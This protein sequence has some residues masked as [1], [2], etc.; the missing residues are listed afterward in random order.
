[1]PVT[2]ALR[3]PSPV[4]FTSGGVW[5]SRRRGRRHRASALLA[6]PHSTSHSPDSHSAR[7]PRQF[8]AQFHYGGQL[9]RDSLWSFDSG[10]AFHR[11]SRRIVLAM[12]ALAVRLLAHF[13]F[14]LGGTTPLPRWLLGRA[15]EVLTF[16]RFTFWATLMAMP[17][18]GVLAVELLDR[19]QSKAAIVSR[20]RRWR[21]LA[22]LCFG[23]TPIPF[24][25]PPL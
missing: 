10:S 7:Q 11:D 14:G 17:L 8:P 23:S 16:E 9:F 5:S 13:Y 24:G 3:D 19:F 15:Y 22:L 4:C 25:P 21:R 20:S 1:M 12:E 2:N 18:V 6:G